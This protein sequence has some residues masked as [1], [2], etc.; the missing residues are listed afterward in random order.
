MRTIPHAI[1][2]TAL[3]VLASCR[4]DLP[5]DVAHEFAVLRPLGSRSAPMIAAQISGSSEPSAGERRNAAILG[6]ALA[7]ALRDGSVRQEVKQALAGSL[8]REHKLELASFLE[9]RGGN[10]LEASQRNGGPG[11]LEVQRAIGGM[12]ELEFYMPVAAHRRAWTGAQEILIAVALDK[13]APPV[14]FT[15]D[16]RQVALDQ[17]HPPA[18]PTLVATTVETDLRSQAVANRQG[19]GFP[20]M[21]SATESLE[22]AGDR[23]EREAN[24]RSPGA[25]ASRVPLPRATLASDPNA[26]GLYMTFLRLLDA[27]EY[28]WQGEP[29]IEVHV[30]G[31]RA[32]GGAVV[33]YQCAGEHAA[34]PF[35]LQPG[36][37][38][39]SYY[40]DM[41]ANFWSGS[42]LL[43]SPAQ[44]DTLQA[45]MPAGF[46][47]SVWEDDDANGACVVRPKNGFSWADAVAATQ[48]VSRGI[49]A[50]RVQNGPGYRLLAEALHALYNIFFPE[51]D[52]YNGLIVSKDSTAY[53]STY[54]NN[55][56]VVYIGG[57]LNGRATLVFK[58]T[59]YTP[60]P[61]GTVT[62]IEISP[63]TDTVGVGNIRQFSAVAYDASGRPVTGAAISW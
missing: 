42:V 12:R 51:G 61:A 39:Q 17:T 38:S 54:P 4:S 2:F 46:N 43:L 8:V 3:L 24:S 6:R 27:H 37:R 14:A 60:P 20:C 26:V 62:S 52:D 22:A 41:N 45:Q 55:T 19:L 63:A 31:R 7:Q 34:D 58:S 47:V 16:G 23:C 44:V 28:W 5:T 33:D 1:P 56:H 57:S 18:T 49:D 9:G 35:G 36:I 25:A 48:A 50:I 11:T 21:A 53:A 29:E 30:T 15:S 40:F 13:S 59:S 32:S 10:I